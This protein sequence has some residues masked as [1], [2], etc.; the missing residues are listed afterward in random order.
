VA[1]PA[2][3]TDLLDR[4][5]L[6]VTGKGGVGKTSVAAALGSLAASRGRRTLLCEVDAKGNLAGA[7]ETAPTQFREREIAPRLWAMTMDTEAS[8]KEYLAL[9]LKLPLLA[10]LR[11]LARTFDFV[12]NAAPGVKEILTVGKLCYE[13][14]EHHYDLVVVDAPASGH[15]VGQLAAPE[16]INDL[17]K[18]GL[19]RDQTGWMLDILGDAATTGVVVVSTPEE[20]PVNET[21]ELAGRLREETVVDLAGVVV[22]RVLPELFTRGEEKIFRELRRPDRAEALAAAVGVPGPPGRPGRGSVEPLL[23]GA[24]LAVKLRRTRAEHLGTLRQ[25][26]PPGTQLLYVPELFQRS[27][28]VRATRQIAEALGAELGY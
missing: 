13:V 22:N 16:A 5:L 9:Q 25:G 20:M 26:L 23:D 15:I 3:P 12:A 24:D 6:F 8:L 21:L 19:V 17:V 7:F 11:P 10:R 4:R 28:G 18:V 14:R 27:H 1:P 2:P